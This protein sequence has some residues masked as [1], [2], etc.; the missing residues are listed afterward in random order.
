[1][2]NFEELYNE[3][4]NVKEMQDVGKELDAE[5]K[6][7]NK[8]TLLICL[9]LD[10]L[11]LFFV[12]KLFGLSVMAILISI[13]CM[14]IPDLIVGFIVYLCMNTEQKKY[15]QVFKAKIITRLI[16]NFYADSEYFPNKKMPE[17]IY[18]QGKY[19]SY[20][21]YYS[22]DY[23]EAK[24]DNKYL[25]DIA[26]VDTERE[27][28][29][30]DSDG[31]THTRCYSVFHGMFA[32][33][34][35]EKSINA[36]LRIAKYEAYKNK[37][38]MDSSEFEKAFNVYTSDKI[39]GMQILTADVMDDILEFKNK[40]KKDFDIYINNENIYLRFHCGSIFEPRIMKKQILDEKSLKMYYNILKFTN[41]LSKKIIKAV[42]DTEI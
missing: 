16:E 42:E 30:K 41:E 22:D 32:K 2:K 25:I 27:E 18:K 24:I 19:E 11:I 20:D 7:R 31:N 9:V 1:M 37:L 23:I 15:I 10:I 38:E 39:I 8:T 17:E 36:N 26:E 21:N 29:Y 34:V 28:T 14:A 35:M 13:V 40:T 6:K 5:I 3:L 4:K 33:I 12:Y